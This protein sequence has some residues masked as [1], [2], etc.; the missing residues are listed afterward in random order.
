MHPPEIIAIAALTEGDRIIGNNGKVP[1]RIPADMERFK[2][3]T[4]GHTVIMG[5]NT[6]EQDLERCP[7]PGRHNI[8][9]STSLADDL[10]ARHCPSNG[11]QLTVAQ[12]LTE[13]LEQ[14]GDRT[15]VFIIGG[16]ILYQSALQLTDTLELTIVESSHIGDTVFPPY[17][18]LIGTEFELAASEQHSGYR[19]E[20][21]RRICTPQPRS[22][23]QESSDR[24]FPDVPR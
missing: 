19:F 6:W 2:Q 17:E 11:Y 1:W 9:V 12:S 10:A 4:K 23:K 8:V 7:L 16:S 18:H 3:L 22:K 15:K 13:A 14:A 21:Y 5:R 20:T 24:H